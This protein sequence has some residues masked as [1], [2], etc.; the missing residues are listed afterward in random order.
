[1]YGVQGSDK[2][3]LVA[4]VLPKHLEHF[5]KWRYWD[6]A[7]WNGDLSKIAGVTDKVS[8]ELSVSPLPDGRYALVFQVGTIGTTIGMRIG[9][10]PVGPFGPIIKLWD[11]TEALVQ[12]NFFA[13]NAKA[14]PSLSGPGELLISYNVNSFDFLNDIKRHPNLYRP[15]FIKVKLQ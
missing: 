8:N 15:R 10:S 9:S 11:T 6:G 12:Q 7:T 5:D 2:S 1:M 3:L 13:Y 4:R 14:H